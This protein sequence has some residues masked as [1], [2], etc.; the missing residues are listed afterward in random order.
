[1]FICLPAQG[2][3]EALQGLRE[4]VETEAR[5]LEQLREGVGDTGGGSGL[6]PSGRRSLSTDRARH[7]LATARMARDLLKQKLDGAT[8]RLQVWISLV[9]QKECPLLDYF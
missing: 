6:S 8:R 5:R 9:M 1:M 3:S 4:L 2:E 7:S